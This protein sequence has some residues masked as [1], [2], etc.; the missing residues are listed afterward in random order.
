MVVFVLE[1]SGCGF[2]S[3]CSYLIFRY[4][5]YFKQEDPWHSGNYIVY[6]HCETRAWRDKDIH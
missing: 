2:E 1:L 6:I 4:R 5:A 3:H